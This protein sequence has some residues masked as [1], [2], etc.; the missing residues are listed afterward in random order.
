MGAFVSRIVERNMKSNQDFM[1]E[2]NRITVIE[3][4]KM[5]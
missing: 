4:S 1:L 2:M 5:C 3:T